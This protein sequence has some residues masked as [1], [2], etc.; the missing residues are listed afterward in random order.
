[1]ELERHVLMGARLRRQYANISADYMASQLGIKRT[2]YLRFERGER[3]PYLDHALRI[4]AVLGCTIDEL[5][6]VP[7]PDEVSDLYREAQRRKIVP[8]D[9]ETGAIIAPPPTSDTS[10][11]SEL[12][13]LIIKDDG[14]DDNLVE[15][16]IKPGDTVVVGDI[17]TTVA[18]PAAPGL[19]EA[20]AGWDDSD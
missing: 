4:A 13:N 20:L 8:I 2:S 11:T 14:A 18:E 10:N 6:R 1:M 17:H 16:P 19:A 3:R 7:T 15:Q 9:D 5:T 12:D